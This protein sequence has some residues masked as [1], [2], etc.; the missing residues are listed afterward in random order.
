MEGTMA[1]VLPIMP[2]NDDA[3]LYARFA[4]QV[5]GETA[6]RGLPAVPVA[7]AL[8]AKSVNV[9]VAEDGPERTAE[10]LGALAA[11]IAGDVGDNR[12]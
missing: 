6:A 2:A 12:A 1:K 5:V 8:L 3:S 10:F 4:D 9:L 11:R 7:V